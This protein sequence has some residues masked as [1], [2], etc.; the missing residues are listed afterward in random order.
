MFNF[1]GVVSF[2]PPG[3]YTTENRAVYATGFLHKNLPK[4]EKKYK[5][6]LTLQ[7]YA[8]NTMF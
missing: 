1:V 8:K 7:E 6:N 2:G 4:H 3:S 5:R